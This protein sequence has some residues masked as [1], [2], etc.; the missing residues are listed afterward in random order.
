MPIFILLTPSKFC[1]K[2]MNVTRN[3]NNFIFNVDLLGIKWGEVVL[4]K[5]LINAPCPM[6]TRITLER[7]GI[8]VEI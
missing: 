1:E 6:Y 2:V 4:D 7:S 3:L 5:L 8:Q